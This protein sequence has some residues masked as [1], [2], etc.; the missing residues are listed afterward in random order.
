MAAFSRSSS[1][2]CEREPEV[3]F[4][5]VSVLWKQANNAWKQSS[6]RSVPASR[7]LLW[8]LWSKMLPWEFR[9]CVHRQLKHY[10]IYLQHCSTG[11]QTHRECKPPTA[12]YTCIWRGR[13]KE[14]KRE[15]GRE[16]EKKKSPKLGSSHILTE[17]Y[18]WQILHHNY[19]QSR[20]KINCM[21]HC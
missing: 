4:C 9:C 12:I 20:H 17:D 2:V 14:L 7:V 21:S 3:M 5:N 8:L 1:S 15:K 10:L 18:R 16:R 11:K 19:I 6:R 13:E